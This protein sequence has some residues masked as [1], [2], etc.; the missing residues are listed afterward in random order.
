MGKPKDTH[1]LLCIT[2]I[3]NQHDCVS[4]T[5]SIRS[6]YL[7]Q[8][9]RAE[10]AKRRAQELR[11]RFR[12]R[13]QMFQQGQQQGSGHS[14]SAEGA[15]GGA[16]NKAASAPR[17]WPKVGVPATMGLARSPQRS[18]V[19]S[20]AMASIFTSPATPAADASSS[21]TT[22]LPEGSSPLHVLDGFKLSP[23]LEMWQARSAQ[24]TSSQVRDGQPFADEEQLAHGFPR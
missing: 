10:L 7:V 12:A 8:A 2:H 4:F 5:I 13:L 11:D 9:A 24:A 14:T 22:A 16:V 3:D 21:P 1:V 23:L 20:G 15:G 6:R 17:K 18:P 19:T